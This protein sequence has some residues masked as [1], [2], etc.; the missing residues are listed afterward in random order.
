MKPKKVVILG[1]GVAGMSAA[2]ELIE[3]GYEVEIYEVN[4]QYVGG[5]ARSVDVPGT[6]LQEP[7]GFLPGEHGFRFFPG[8]YRHVIDT[9][10]RIPFKDKSGKIQPGGVSANLTPTKTIMLARYGKESILVNA[11][12]PRTR[13]GWKLLLNNLFRGVDTGLTDEEKTFFADRMMQL[14]TSC[15][16]RRDNDYEKIGWWEYMQ[17]DNFSETYRNL[18]VI[19]FTRTLVA[20]NAKTASTKTGGDI[21][22]QLIYCGIQPWVNPDRVLNA[23]TNDAW[24]NPWKVY[25]LAKGV[26]YIHDAKVVRIEMQDRKVSSV[27]IS[28][29]DSDAAQRKEIAVQGDHY[30][31]ACPI[32]RMTEL[33]TD[34]M[35]DVDPCFSY[36]KTLAPSVSWMNG[37]QYYLN[38]NVSI[39]KGHIIFSD[40]EWALTAISQIQFWDDYDLSK[41][42]NGKVKGILSVDISDWLHTKYRTVL[43]ED[44]DAA[45]IEKYVWEQI[46]KSLN[47]N[48]KKIID[49]S[50][51]EFY[52]LDRD[53]HW[54]KKKRQ[55]VDKEP[56]LV[57]NVNTW[58]LRPA[59]ATDIENIFLA[60]DYVRTNTDLATMEGANE[61][62]RRAVN[63][64]IDADGNKKHYAQIFQFKE[65]WF[66][67]LMKCW[68]RHRYN[69]GLPY[70]DNFPWYIRTLTFLMGILFVVEGFLK[71][72]F[73]KLSLTNEAG[74]IITTMLGTL[75]VAALSA[76]FDWGPV[77]AFILAW[78]M[79]SIILWY[80]YRRQDAFLKKLLLFG[81]AAGFVELIADNW[82]V[83]GIQSLQYPAHEP[84]LWASPAYM[85]FAWAVILIQVGYIGYLISKKHRLA[86]AAL[87][88][89]IIGILF[90]PAFECFAKYAS[91]WQYI[92][93]EKMLFHTPYY[94]IMGEGLICFV[95]PLIYTRAGQM[96]WLTTL[97]SGIIMGLWIF[98]AYFIAYKI[99]T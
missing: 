12:F 90:I 20:A 56:L 33:I 87:L 40:T 62:A 68:D 26:K 45:T 96:R 47:V 76:W 30:L 1:G 60:A 53:I 84:M 25:L 21:V 67:D 5:K 37:I 78:G 41:R 39:N 98:A 38:E 49:R 24:L 11:R 34:Q 18:L 22:L 69:K 52:Y 82:L 61:A 81:I 97:V 9:M 28:M 72:M 8:F 70:S 71:F 35:I 75:S 46:E 4:T 63:C 83:N 58:A 85:P 32:E 74:F 94:I 54:E 79:Y 16:R 50:M 55:N 14:A 31:F 65:P 57:N 29:H 44:C 43:A 93:T 23:P 51:V 27:V 99:T 66:F 2:Q 91:W 10:S 59:A 7:D 89:F 17:A 92:P 42:Y 95:L 3:R 80:A 77:S 86:T 13:A 73:S 48:G 36:L 15:R 6:N 88:T 19:G 64:I